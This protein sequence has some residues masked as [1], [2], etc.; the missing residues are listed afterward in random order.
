MQHTDAVLIVAHRLEKLKYC[1]SMIAIKD[2]EK[3]NKWYIMRKSG[4]D[5]SGNPGG[6]AP[7]SAVLAVHH[8]L[9]AA[10]A[11]R[12]AS[13]RTCGRGAKRDAAQGLTPLPGQRADRAEGRPRKHLFARG[14]ILCGEVE[15]YAVKTIGGLRPGGEAEELFPGG[16]GPLSYPAHRERALGGAGGRPGGEGGDALHTER[17]ADPRGAGPL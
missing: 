5:G 16:G 17:G 13:K 2:I 3:N 8:G 7:R 10:A 15:P 1:F 9:R 14:S 11:R 6:R 12:P 4:L